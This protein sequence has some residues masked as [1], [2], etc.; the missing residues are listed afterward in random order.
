MK[1]EWRQMLEKAK[2]PIGSV[3]GSDQNS[4][5]CLVTIERLLVYRVD[6]Y[7]YG[8][9]KLCRYHENY[10]VLLECHCLLRGPE[11]A[12]LARCH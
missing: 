11:I 5:S 12:A 4:L 7:G 9:D 3:E 10:E 6:G 2:G 1:L 8:S